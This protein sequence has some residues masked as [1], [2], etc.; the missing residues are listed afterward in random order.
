MK[1]YLWLSAIVF[2]MNQNNYFGWNMLPHSDAELIA[3]GITLILSSMAML[4]STNKI[5][6]HVTYNN[7][8]PT[9][10]KE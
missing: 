10:E 4:A 7:E 5:T 3:D 9:I 6:I 8:K 1:F 2:F